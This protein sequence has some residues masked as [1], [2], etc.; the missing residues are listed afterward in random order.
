MIIAIIPTGT[1]RIPIEEFRRA[2]DPDAAVADFCGEY[3][4]PRKPSDYLGHDIGRSDVPPA[5]RGK[6]WF[7]DHDAGSLVAVAVTTREDE[8]DALRQKRRDGLTLTA[9]EKTQ[10][11]DLLL[12]V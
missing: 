10:A 4:P 9:A 5:G 8:L 2:A 12:G 1:G 7:Y 6:R 3:S 11:I